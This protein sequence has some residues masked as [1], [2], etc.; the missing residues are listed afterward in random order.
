M[1]LGSPGELILLE[2]CSN[3]YRAAAKITS[4]SME[5]LFVDSEAAERTR[6]VTLKAAEKLIVFAYR[7]ARTCF[8]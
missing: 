7:S 1:A 3:S 4:R 2:S 6:R 5:M 8:Q